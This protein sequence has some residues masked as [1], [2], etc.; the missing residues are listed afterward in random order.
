MGFRKFNSQCFRFDG[1]RVGKIKIEITDENNFVN[2]DLTD[3]GKGIVASMK[4]DVF[5]PG[6]STKQRGWGLGLSLA[7]EL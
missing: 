4:K 3:S 6:F 5:R 1:V 2:V 7:K